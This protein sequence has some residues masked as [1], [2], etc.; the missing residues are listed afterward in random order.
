MFTERA[1]GE[2]LLCEEIDLYSMFF[3][4]CKV[5]R[6]GGRF[7]SLTTSFIVNVE[8]VPFVILIFF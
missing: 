2:I 1:D 7:E 8:G 4:P 5:Y 6:W 3:K